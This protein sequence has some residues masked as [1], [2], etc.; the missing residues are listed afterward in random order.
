[1]HLLAAPPLLRLHQPLGVR[2]PDRERELQ[3]IRR[4]VGM[5][6]AKGGGRPKGAADPPQV[7]GQTLGEQA[8][9]GPALAKAAC[10]PWMHRQR[11]PL[12]RLLAHTPLERRRQRGIA[13]EQGLYS[14]GRRVVGRAAGIER[15]TLDQVPVQG[16]RGG[17]LGS[18]GDRV[19]AAELVI[20]LGRRMARVPGQQRL[21]RADEIEAAGEQALEGI[22]PRQ[23][24]G[25]N[26]A[27]AFGEPGE[28]A[29][30]ADRR[31]RPDQ[32]RLLDEERQAGERAG[33]PQ[34][35]RSAEQERR[36]EGMV[37]DRGMVPQPRPQHEP[38]ARQL[39]VEGVCL[40]RAGAPEPPAR[41]FPHHAVEQAVEARIEALDLRRIVGHAISFR[42]VPINRGL[43]L[44]Y[45]S[46]CQSIYQEETGHRNEKEKYWLRI[47]LIPSGTKLRGGGAGDC[48]SRP[49]CC[50]P[51]RWDW[52]RAWSWCCCR[53][54]RRV[55][56]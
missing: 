21:L 43:M 48:R 27:P 50:S 30:A 17:E 13:L 3:H 29:L 39:E 4:V 16:K 18:V 37:A 2:D 14:V 51:C 56:A 9:E 31:G 25:L 8:R 5:E 32:L 26:V 44:L 6:R 53:C 40:R 15:A 12:G 22:G 28:K 36:L 24:G 7:L 41:H 46:I 42:V 49:S 10:L 38:P 19:V 11:Q 33:R 52:G 1:M 54:S 55:A 20:A 34:T 47:C 23:H 45:P 35:L